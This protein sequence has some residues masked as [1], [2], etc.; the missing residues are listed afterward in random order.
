MPDR[1]KVV[2][3][4]P[5]AQKQIDP[6]QQHFW[7]AGLMRIETRFACSCARGLHW[8][9]MA[10][11]G[12]LGSGEANIELGPE[13]RRSRKP[14]FCLGPMHCASYH[15]KACPGETTVNYYY[16]VVQ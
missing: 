4:E 3:S 14:F 10:Q 5:T 13:S 12:S 6:R 8:R 16:H 9:S 7:V 2:Q 15:F 11:E 1:L